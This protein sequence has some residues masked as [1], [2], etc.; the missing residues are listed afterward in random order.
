MTR[1]F[2]RIHLNWVRLLA[3]TSL[4]FAAAD[5]G[6]TPIELSSSHLIKANRTDFFSDMPNPCVESTNLLLNV[7]ENEA[8]IQIT[9]ANNQC[10]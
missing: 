6:M 7:F 10:K 2:Q 4:V 5:T 1:N 9:Y 8:T 3:K